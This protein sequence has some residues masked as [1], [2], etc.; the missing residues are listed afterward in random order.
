MDSTRG[1]GWSRTGAAMVK[2]L[3]LASVTAELL[4]L[5]ERCN[6]LFLIRESQFLETEDTA[7]VAGGVG[8]G[9]G[10]DDG[11]VLVTTDIDPQVE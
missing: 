8:F 11:E 10:G 5:A 1:A 7:H 9:E 3:L 4:V 2:G 6:D